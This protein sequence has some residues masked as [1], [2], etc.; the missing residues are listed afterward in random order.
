[1]GKFTVFGGS[2][3]IGSEFVKEIRGQG[4][5]VFVPTREDSRIYEEDLGVI[6]YSAGYGDCQKDPFNVLTANVL[7]LSSLLQKAKFDKLVYISSTRVYMNQELSVENSDLTICEND[8]RRLF[9]LTKLT[10]EEL[11]LK[12]KR[13]CLVIRPSNV[14][15]LA[16]NSPLFL[17]SIIRDAVNKKE[18]T[19]FVS[20]N[21]SKDYIAVTDV[22]DV[23]LKI[24]NKNGHPNIVNIASGENIKASE[25]A[26]ILID[27]LDCKVNWV[28]NYNDVKEV[29]PETN[30]DFITDEI[31]F[32]ARKVL[33][34]MNK[35][36]EDYKSKL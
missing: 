33:L 4:H 31:K 24:L 35:M 36:I 6:I 29:F 20:K 12:S 2:G 28:E 25:I 9:N 15:G 32:K 34:D 10:A 23:T 8:T 7:L 3:F 16:L 5:D 1:M 22:V 14:Y 11:C 18:V 30:I 19:M 17:P 27:K 26:K 13:N 21:Y